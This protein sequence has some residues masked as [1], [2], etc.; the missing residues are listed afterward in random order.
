MWVKWEK[1]PSSGNRTIF[2]RWIKN[3]F[4]YEMYTD[5]LFNPMILNISYLRKVFKNPSVY[6]IWWL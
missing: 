5:Q 2:T 3:S 4:S 1:M 6:A